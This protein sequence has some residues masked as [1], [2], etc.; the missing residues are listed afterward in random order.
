MPTLRGERFHIP[1]EDEDIAPDQS[2]NQEQ[3]GF[4]ATGVL[5]EIMERKT[6][7]I[8]VAPT[9][10]SG[11]SSSGWPSHRKRYIPKKDRPVADSE[12]SLFRHVNMGE[13][14]MEERQRREIDEENQ[15]QIDQMSPEEIEQERNE[16]LA[17]LD[18]ELVKRFLNR[19]NN[20][21]SSNQPQ[22]TPWH[23]GAK[24]P[25]RPSVSERKVSFAVP[26][27]NM[28][29]KLDR[30]ISAE[31]HSV[32]PPSKPLDLPVIGTPPSRPQ[33]TASTDRKVS[34]TVPDAPLDEEKPT[35]SNH[36]LPLTLSV[37][38]S[39][40]SSSRPESRRS[41]GSGR[42]VSFSI[43]DDIEVAPR[44]PSASSHSIPS[45]SLSAEPSSSH[46]TMAR[47]VS[48]NDRKVSFSLPPAVQ[49]EPQSTAT[50]HSI[51]LAEPIVENSEHSHDS[52]PHRPHTSERKV[53]FATPVESENDDDD[54]S[55]ASRHSLPSTPLFNPVPDVEIVH[56]GVH[57]PKP[58]QP[59]LDPESN[60]FLD[61][62]HQKYFPSLSHDPSKLDWMKP[63]D[64]QESAA[65]DPNQVD[66]IDPKD[67]RFDFRGKIIPPSKSLALPTTLGL[68]N[69]A[70]APEA[71]GYT[72]AELSHLARSAYPAQR[73]IA[74]QTLGRLLYRLGS[75]EYG[76]EEDVIRKDVAGQKAML[77]KGLWQEVEDGRAI[78]TISEWA[79]KERGHQTSIV[80][81]QEALWNWQR[82]GG[83]PQKE[84]DAKAGAD[85]FQK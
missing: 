27:E 23:G 2:V 4:A 37:S 51:P 15:R 33:R 74:I 41:S 12:N 63:V 70:A 39:S 71:A 10:P 55:T 16:L 24:E 66:E 72:I 20:S 59:E 85:A 52:T 45:P 31:Q 75:G 46:P 19:S 77:A 38:N 54:R 50:S 78:E 57:F 5:G 56:E 60:T 22:S 82:G 81:S 79:K 76:N 32:P 49:E 21:Q 43:P 11:G 26:D 84:A 53:S 40:E 83:R 14:T 6:P 68:H 29:P 73:C 61:D 7:N 80:L 58:V 44:R 28:E 34:F 67:V 1:L 65:Y 62:L 35:A 3:P 17:K 69:H 36:S 42:K 9:F 64:P 25:K 30:R 8:P 47:R 48:S 13:E 18:P